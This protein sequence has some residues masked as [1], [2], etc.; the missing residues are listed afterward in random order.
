MDYE[1]LKTLLGHLE[2]IMETYKSSDDEEDIFYQGIKIIEE[3]KNELC[4]S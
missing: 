1:K 2:D 3:I 4:I